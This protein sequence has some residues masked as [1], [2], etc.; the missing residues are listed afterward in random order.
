MKALLALWV[1]ASSTAAFA[2]GFTRNLMYDAGPDAMVPK[3]FSP[4]SIEAAMARLHDEVN[5]AC[6]GNEPARLTW[7]MWTENPRSYGRQT[8]WL[9]GEFNCVSLNLEVEP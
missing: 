1:M 6:G 7:R 4:I 8:F 3:D 2:G 5:Q 9:K